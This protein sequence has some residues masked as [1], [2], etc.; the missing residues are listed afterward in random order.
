MGTGS[1][2]DDVEKFTLIARKILGERRLKA[3]SGVGSV[4][5]LVGFEKEELA[6]I[7][8]RILFDVS[9]CLWLWDVIWEKV[10]FGVYD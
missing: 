3:A 2:S 1:I 4:G 5:W 7:E 8:D 9:I 10:I 6:L